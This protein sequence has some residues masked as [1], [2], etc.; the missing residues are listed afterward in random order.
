MRETGRLKVDETTN[1]RKNGLVQKC[2]IL[3][4]S[5]GRSGELS[6]TDGLVVNL[7]VES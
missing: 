6:F 4:N 5:F 3:G 2:L 7:F 1:I